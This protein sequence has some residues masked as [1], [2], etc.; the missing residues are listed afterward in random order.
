MFKTYYDRFKKKDKTNNRHVRSCTLLMNDHINVVHD[1]CKI[2]WDKPPETTLEGKL[3]YINNRIKIGHESIL[4]HSNVV[5]YFALPNTVDYSEE[6]VDIM[7]ALKYL[8]VHTKYEGD[9]IHVLIGGSIR[10]YKH[11]FRNTKE[12]T[13]VV[14]RLIQ[15]EI[16]ENLNKEYFTDFINDGIMV[17]DRFT[18]DYNASTPESMGSA[19]DVY[20]SDKVYVPYMDK[21]TN[22]RDTPFTFREIFDMLTITVL[23]KNMSRTGTHQLV[24][25]R[26]AI[27]QESQRYV[28]YRKA[29]F[30]DP[31]TYKPKY[32]TSKKYKC[33]DGEY[34]TKELG[35]KLLTIYGDL[36][37]QGLDRED[38]RAFLPNNVQCGK[39]YMTFTFT[40]F[41]KFLELRCDKAAQGEIREY[42]NELKQVFDRMWDMETLNYPDN[43]FSLLKPLYSN[44]LANLEIDEVLGE[45]EVVEELD[46]ENV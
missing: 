38:A 35:D 9:T 26:N 5:M 31:T 21:I 29:G 11:V 37:E 3:K 8:N 20:E 36:R 25:H 14:V 2:C 17:E 27:T 30:T 42:A 13:N 34:T 44:E 6:L 24:R 18:F 41:I 46:S 32:D 45:S 15:K 40:N 43:Y 1:A 33:L 12:L 28:D 22:L 10:A 16:Y 19:R 39:L 23:F 4:E 7:P